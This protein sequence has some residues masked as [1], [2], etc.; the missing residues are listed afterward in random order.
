[1]QHSQ[2][3]AASSAEIL[4]DKQIEA[5][6]ICSSTST[7][8]DLIEQAAKAGKHIFCEKPI[9]FSLEQIDHARWPR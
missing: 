8:A 6:L 4:A 2:G 7:H 3:V 1:L 5:V 9:A